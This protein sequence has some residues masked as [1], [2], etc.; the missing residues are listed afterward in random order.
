MLD[1]LFGFDTTTQS[2]NFEKETRNRPIVRKNS[3]VASSEN[4]LRTSNFHL[5]W[6]SAMHNT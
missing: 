2:G 1:E 5:V 3:F 6:N 4:G